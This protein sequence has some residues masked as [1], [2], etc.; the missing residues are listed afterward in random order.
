MIRYL[1]QSV[2]KN[3]EKRMTIKAT[4]ET[5]YLFLREIR[6]IKQAK[7]PTPQIIP[8]QT[9]QQARGDAIHGSF[10]LKHM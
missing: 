2:E 10:D 5:T 4:K 6:E 7:Y 3:S 9:Q 8:S 1:L